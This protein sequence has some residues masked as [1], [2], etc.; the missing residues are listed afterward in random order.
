MA[1]KKASSVSTLSSYWSPPAN[2]PIGGVGEPVACVAS[3]F[4]F[5]SAFLETELL[6]RFLGLKYDHTE[7]EL[8]FLVEREEKLAQVDVAV[9]VDIHKVDPGQTTLRWDQVPI[10]VPGSAAVQHSKIVVLAWERAVRLILGSANLTRTGYRRNRE[11]FATLDFYDHADSTPRR[12]AE[13]AV[14]F[15]ESMLAWSRVPDA[16]RERTR[17]TLRSIRAAV[18]NWTLIPAD[19]RPREKPRVSFIATHPRVNDQSP[20]S[21]IDQIASLWGS[22]SASE[23]TVFTPFV[24]QAT[25][26]EDQVIRRVAAIP[27]SRDCIGWLVVPRLPADPT[28]P[29]IRIPFP[30]SF[31]HSWQKHFA[32]RGGGRVLAIPQFVNGVD[33]IQRVFHS[34]LLVLRSD[35]H[36]LLMLGSSNFTP[37][38]MGV[39]V[40]NLEANLV[41][42]MSAE[43]GWKGIE[44]PLPWEAGIPVDEVQWIEPVEP[45][46][47]LV[48][49]AETLPRFFVC[50]S[51]SQVSG[52]L[53]VFL[54]RCANEP[55]D[56]TIRLQGNTADEFTLFHSGLVNGEEVLTYAF[57]EN[58]RAANL[59]S[60]V[61]EWQDDLG[62]ERQARLIVSVENKEDLTPSL[63]FPGFGVDAMLDCLIHGRS[64][65]EWQERQSNSSP[66]GG[67]IP[68]A[69][70]SLRAIDT[71]G[72]LLYQVRRFGRAIAG[73]CE[74]LER[75]ALIPTA[76]RYRCFQ[77]P[78]GPLSVAAAL[79]RTD[80]QSGGSFAALAPEQRLFLVSELLLA[81]SHTIR[82]ML[83]LTD[84]TLR[85]WLRPVYGELLNAIAS[86]LTSLRGECEGTLSANLR[87]YTQ[88]VLD[89]ALALS[90]QP[91]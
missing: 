86:S 39:G 17:E 74:R 58:Q 18:A 48:D 21:T 40:F 52:L 37:H 51:Y 65:A 12:L 23:V 66:R 34:K 2:L 85:I 10:A 75:V 15:L 53:Q 84:P 19:F 45:Q 60:L 1:K 73:L 90:D 14:V 81:V 46:G 47:D 70:D 55:I 9:L 54:D 82:R 41:F 43:E 78:L 42:E 69:I 22:R 24:G 32:T 7:N 67:G 63:E 26:A 3:T 16:T 49:P 8:T 5:Q 30:P 6:P 35:D 28:D 33:K 4:E 77:D 62:Q 79:I 76:V 50:A 68:E 88:S 83:T 25:Q 20:S 61:V 13:D 31:G 71:S 59:A 38:G 89:E 87:Q 57:A 29:V 64:L 36:E 80:S 72:Y 44:V 11:V 56:W 91:L 27:R